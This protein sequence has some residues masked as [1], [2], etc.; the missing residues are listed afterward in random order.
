[1]LQT[2]THK[3][4]ENCMETG[5]CENPPPSDDIHEKLKQLALEAQRHPPLN[6]NR[7]LALNQLARELYQLKKI[8]PNLLIHPP[9]GK[10]PPGIYDELYQEALQKT[11]LYVCQKIDNYNPQHPVIAWV[12]FTLKNRFS[13]VAKEYEKNRGISILSLDKLDK[14][15]LEKTKREPSLELETQLVQQLREFLEEDPENLFKYAHIRNHPEATFQFLAIAKFVEG[16]TWQEISDNLGI[17]IP[18][19]SSFFSRRLHNF[20]PYFQKYL[21]E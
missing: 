9:R 15:I 19:L 20:L 7:Q 21:Q 8:K 14:Y 6:R 2:K 4:R 16:K 18:A 17:G 12:N 1:M 11:Y 10:W 5:K 13:E 3:I